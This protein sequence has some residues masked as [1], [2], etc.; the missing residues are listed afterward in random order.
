ML[1][2]CTEDYVHILPTDYRVFR[3]CIT[4]SVLLCGVYVYVFLSRLRTLESSANFNE[5]RRKYYATSGYA[6]L[7]NY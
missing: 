5:T 3:S 7:R 1:I 4:F 6:I 2:K